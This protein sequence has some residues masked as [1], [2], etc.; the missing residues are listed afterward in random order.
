MAVT[1]SSEIISGNPLVTGDMTINGSLTVN[2]N[3][4]FGDAAVDTLDINGNVTHTPVAISTGA[5]VPWT[6]TGAADTGMTTTVERP[7][8]Y[9]NGARTATW[10]AGSITAQRQYKFMAET[11][12]IAGAGGTVANA[13]TLYI[14]RAPQ[15]GTGAT[16]TAAWALWVDAGSSRFD[17]DVLITSGTTTDSLTITGSTLTTGSGLVITGPS[18]ATAG[19]T[20]ALVKLTS[21]IGNCGANV[22]AFG[23][24]SSTATLDTST[25]TTDTSG[26]LY[27]STVNSNSSFANSSFGSYNT[28]TDAVALANTNYGS[29]ITVANTGAI[30]S[31]ITKTI[32]GNYIS[33]SGTLGAPT[34][35]GTTLVYGEYITTTA[36]HAG[37]FGTVNQYGLYIANGTSGTNGAST[38]YGLY[39][40]TPTGADTNYAIYTVGGDVSLGGS[41]YLPT[42]LTRIA[43]TTGNSLNIGETTLMGIDTNCIWSGG[44]G[45]VLIA[46]QPTDGG[47]AIAV[48]L[49]S[50]SALATAG[51]KIVSFMNSTAEKAS[52]DLYGIYNHPTSGAI[53]ASTTQTQGNGALTATVNNVSVCAN[54]NDTV[55]LP[56]A[57][58]GRIVYV[59]N[60]GAQTLKIFPASGD[61]LG[62]GADTAKTLAAAKQ[63]MFVAYDATNWQPVLGANLL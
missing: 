60:N 37:N 30:D 47:S 2:T 38:K 24:I 46:G 20:D 51:A 11:I 9:W 5:T 52:I 48:Y 7:D 10:A 31:A 23:L 15:A 4:T 16:L 62:A 3:L 44:A 33:A 32:I 41:L 57:S 21:D 29:Y 19:V 22:P 63:S 8:Y 45:N 61:N 6:F 40:A 17:G 14:D 27:L 50:H 43:I 26:N 35:A 39:I 56:T 49:G 36:A 13:A 1:R 28:L 25:A 18:G 42:A 54:T 59:F 58:A 55:T 34:T 53:T 12:A